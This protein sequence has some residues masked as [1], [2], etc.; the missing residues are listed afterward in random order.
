MKRTPHTTHIAWAV[1]SLCEICRSIPF[2]KI[3]NNDEEAIANDG[4]RFNSIGRT[5]LSFSDDL[6]WNKRRCTVSELVSRAKSC[7]FCEHVLLN[8]KDA[9]WARRDMIE[10]MAW[11]EAKT[12]ISRNLMIWMHLFR[13]VDR[14]T[15]FSISLGNP[16]RSETRALILDLRKSLSKSHSTLA[17]VHRN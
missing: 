11:E 2:R 1:M 13:S 9:T 4:F 14:G 7:P 5:S 12:T 3:F 17:R 10:S 8:V 15:R 6:P 16:H